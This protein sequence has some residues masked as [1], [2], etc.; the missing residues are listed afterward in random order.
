[1]ID[2]FLQIIIFLGAVFQTVTGIGFA[3][4]TGPFLLISI[5]DS[6]AIQVNIL[7]NIILSLTIAT[8]VF[9]YANKKLLIY[10][11]M[12]TLVGLPIGL[13]CYS[14][15]DVSTLKL[16]IGCLV[17]LMSIRLIFASKFINS[18]LQSSRTNELI[19][20]FISGILTAFLAMPGPALA[21][22][23][24]ETGIYDKKT[25][26]STILIYFLFAYSLSLINHIAFIGVK[27]IAYK[28][29][30]YYLPVTIVGVIVG[31]QL[32]SKVSEEFFRF[33]IILVLALTSITMIFSSLL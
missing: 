1:M 10:I 5:N 24:S 17:G 6:Y 11:I 28:T 15:V 31:S 29:A 13:L 3:M 21:T 7:L 14:N 26:R 4:I 25:T 9:K 2:I 18:R 8:R 33:L 12:G 19:T 30:I 16:I 32:V 20:G 23:M 22:Y 27:V